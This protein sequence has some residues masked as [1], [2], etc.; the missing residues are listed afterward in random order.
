M[1][2]VISHS[3]SLLLIDKFGRKPLH[4]IGLSGMCAMTIALGT[5]LGF[6]LNANTTVA[7]LSVAFVLIFVA[8]FQCGPGSIPWFISAELFAD[9]D[10]PRAMSIAAGIN[11]AA[12]AAVGFSYPLLNDLIGGATFYIFAGLLSIFIAFTFFKVPETK[13]KSVN[14]VQMYF[15]PHNDDMSTATSL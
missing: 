14:E 10:R 11:W 2:A 6:Y 9:V 5:V 7:S 15:D 4:L 3:F 13:N 1:S 12:N 8:F